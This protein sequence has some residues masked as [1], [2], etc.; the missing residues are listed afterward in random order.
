MNK[1]KVKTNNNF[2][3]W[4]GVQNL[5]LLIIFTL[6]FFY[7]SVIL[8]FMFKNLRKINIDKKSLYILF[9]YPFFFACCWIFAGINMFYSFL[10]NVPTGLGFVYTTID[11]SLVQI[12]C[13]VNSLAYI[14]LH[15]YSF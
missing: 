9:M 1:F 2:C 15:H 8:Y 10:Y 7:I 3:G 12:N 5:I 11:G 13:I 4:N 6:V 14:I